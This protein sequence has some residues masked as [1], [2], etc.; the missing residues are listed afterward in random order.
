MYAKMVNAYYELATLFYE[1][2]WGQSFHFAQKKGGESFAESI[3]RH[4]YYLASQ[5][6]VKPGMRVLDVGCGIGG[7]YRNIARFTQCDITGVTLN[8]Y[9]VKRANEL[10]RAAGLG[11]QVRSVQCDFMK[12]EPFADASFDAVY[13]IEA[14]CHAPVRQGV[15]G[16]ILRVLK[17]GAVFA[18]YEWCLTDKYDTANAAHRKIKKAIEE[19]DGLPDMARPQEVVA[20]LTDVGFEV[21]HTRDMALDTNLHG[22][23]WYLPLMPSWK[24]WTQR[25]QFTGAR[26]ALARP[27]VPARLHAD[28]PSPA[29]HTTPLAPPRRGRDVPDEE[30]AVADGGLL[31][32]AQGHVQGAADAAAGRHRLLAGRRH[33]HVH[34]HVPLRLP[35]AARQQVRLCLRLAAARRHERRRAQLS[36]RRA[37]QRARQCEGPVSTSCAAAARHFARQLVSGISPYADTPMT[38]VENSLSLTL[39][40]SSVASARGERRAPS[41]GSYRIGFRILERR[42]CTQH[43]PP[44]VSAMEDFTQ[45]TGEADPFGAAGGDD[46]F[47][48]SAPPLD[49]EPSAGFAAEPLD[50]VDAGGAGMGDFADAGGGDFG[51]GG[52]GEMGGSMGEMGGMDVMGG[53]GSAGDM[54]G[55]G[56]MGDMG[57]LDVMG[58]GGSTRDAGGFGSMGDM[59]ALGGEANGSFGVLDMATLADPGPPPEP[60][61]PKISEASLSAIA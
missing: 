40:L 35:Q 4:E 22:E 44:R 51:G 18:C 28:R 61:G 3:R 48:M 2:G 60:E 27:P 19:G 23:P 42:G 20:A 47:G 12:M 56:S 50:G 6:E 37:A 31:P 10:N 8:E 24:V 52:M 1:W 43:P 59:G 16:E 33:R 41:G 38:H 21:L 15:Y 11:A 25:F 34:A 14:T 13:A 30:R 57:S 17:P 29:L 26:R 55:G 45:P 39:W 49:G 5:L 9:Q 53:G 32:R 58:R 46:A 7:P 54:G 36:S